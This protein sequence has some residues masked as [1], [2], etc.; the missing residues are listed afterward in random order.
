MTENRRPSYQNDACRR[1]FTLTEMLCIMALIAV[2]G[3]ILT[4]LLR[5]TL[6]IEQ[7]QARGF[8][9]LLQTKALAD[10]FRA[11]VAQAESA[12]PLGEPYQADAQTLI[13]QMKNSEHIVYRWQ[14]GELIRLAIKD[15]V[16]TERALPIGGKKVGVE[17]VHAH[18]SS[19]VLRLRLTTLRG[20]TPVPGQTLE[21]AAALGGDW[22]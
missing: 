5:E 21:I 22:R 8:D 10:Q 7:V 18:A 11:D 12:P 9:K 2:L 20:A 14:E 1:G 13:L 19:K 15:Q 16:Q 17:F 4:L 3:I 6:Q